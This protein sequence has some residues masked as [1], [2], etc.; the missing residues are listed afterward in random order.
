MRLVDPVILERLKQNNLNKDAD[1][2]PVVR[3]FTP[4]SRASW[5]IVDI[6]VDDGDTMYGLCDL[7][8]GEANLGYVLLSDLEDIVGPRDMRVERDVNWKPTRRISDYARAAQVA[9]R[10][11]ELY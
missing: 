2:M 7:G 1:H 3:Y 10:V 9:K 8:V 5:L 11:I 4:W 6:D